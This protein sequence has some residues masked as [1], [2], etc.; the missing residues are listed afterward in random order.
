MRANPREQAVSE[1]HEKSRCDVKYFYEAIVWFIFDLINC[2]TYVAVINT[3]TSLR[4]D[5]AGFTRA[6]PRSS[7]RGAALRL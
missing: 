3:S 5:L 1:N 4:T 7:Q 2:H 6:A